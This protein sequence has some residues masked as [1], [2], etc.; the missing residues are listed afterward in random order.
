MKSIIETLMR[1]AAQRWPASL[2]EQRAREWAAELHHLGHWGRLRFAWSLAMSPPVNDDG[3][4]LGWR[5][6]LPGLGR[7]LQPPLALFAGG[8]MCLLLAQWIP[9]FGYGMMQHTDA[10][11]VP[12]LANA[13]SLV[14]LAIVTVFAFFAGRWAGRWLPMRW[15]ALA[16]VVVVGAPLLVELLEVEPFGGHPAFVPVYVS[17]EVPGLLLWAVCFTVVA[18]L[19][20]T[21]RRGRLAGLVGTLVVLDLAA[22]VTAWD[23]ARKAGIGVASAPLWFP[24]ALLDL[25]NNGM[26]LGEMVPSSAAMVVRP[27]LAA[28]VFVLGYAF[29]AKVAVRRPVEVRVPLGQA[30][31]RPALRGWVIAGAGLALWVY[32]LTVLTGALNDFTDEM[33]EH[34]L[35]AHEIRQAAILV[36]VTGLALAIAGRGA[37]VL[38][39][40]LAL[41]TLWAI[42]SVFDARD[43]ANANAALLAAGLGAIVLY[44]AWQLAR[45]FRTDEIAVRRS[46]AGFAVLGASCAPAVAYHWPT[47]NT[48]LPDGFFVA[49]AVVVGLL[50]LAALVCASAV[51]GRPMWIA[52]VVVAAVAGAGS[53]TPFFAAAGVPLAVIAVWFMVPRR[54]VGRRVLVMVAALVAAIPVGLTQMYSSFPFADALMAAA[55]YS[56]PVDGVPFLPGAILVGTVAAIIIASRV[57]PREPFA[58]TVLEVAHMG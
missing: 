26:R 52:A 45:L 50:V 35:W 22:I 14:S 13:V 41:G 43:A 40:V 58:N 53:V 4:P 49:S 37:I 3:V 46:L 6:T 33:G 34:H 29:A 15:A 36:M 38:P 24:F 57:V 27:C 32:A 1:M 21:V 51:R 42:D 12:L 25:D 2:R 30:A 18:A 54:S 20:V 10:H 31:P 23:A 9:R 39:G 19:A 7:A 28:S 55:G 47:W 16:P 56:F 11:R 8:L 5:E 17:Y 44:G 48:R